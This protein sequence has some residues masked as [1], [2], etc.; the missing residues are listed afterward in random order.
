M[1]LQQQPS[2]IKQ[3]EHTKNATLRMMEV[4]L[5]LLTCPN[6]YG[7]KFWCRKHGTIRGGLELVTEAS[8]KMTQGLIAKYSLSHQIAAI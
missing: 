8:N 6:N 2:R 4:K 3:I 1:Y 7:Q 5:L